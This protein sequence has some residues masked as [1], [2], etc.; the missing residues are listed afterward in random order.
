[1]VKRS[2]LIPMM[3]LFDAPEPLVSVGRRP[4]TT[5][6]PQA[7]AFMNNVHVRSWARSLGKKLLP[8]AEKSTADAIREGYMIAVAR[9][10]DEAELAQTTAF[11]D[12]Q[13]K[14]YTEAKQP[15]ARELA[16]ADFAQV[17]LSLNEFIYVD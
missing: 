4:A 5:I 11:I 3:T 15:N 1:M 7:L 12:A 6:A 13:I 16:L 8:A 10:P 2:K 9:P 14:S 17:L